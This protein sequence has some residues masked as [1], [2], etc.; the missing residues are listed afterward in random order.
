M[1]QAISYRDR[2]GFVIVKDQTVQRFVQHSYAGTYDHFIASGLYQHLVGEGLLITHT[3]INLNITE[4][5]KYYKVLETPFIP[6]ISYPYEW[7]A[8][9][10]KE[11][12]L[13]ILEINLI[14]I[15]YGMI[16]KDAT[17]FN[18]TFYHGKCIFID[19][20]SFETYTD[21]EPWIA[22]RQFCESMLGP[23]ALVFFN[24]VVWGR[25]MQSYINGWPLKMIS[26]NLPLHTW[27]KTA[28][29]FHIHLHAGFGKKSYIK[30]RGDGFSKEKLS[31]LWD[32]LKK[33]VTHWKLRSN[34]KIWSDYYDTGILSKQ[35][36]DHKLLMVSDWLKETQPHTVIDFGA[37][38]GLFS[39]TASGISQK[40]I[41]VESDHDCVEHLRQQIT[42]RKIQNIE[43]VLADIT[44]PTVATGWKN[45]E[46]QALLQRLKG[47]MV[48]SLALIHHLCISSNIPLPFIAELFSTL[49]TQYA[50][51]EF[52]PRTDP[53]VTDMLINRKDI[54]QDYTEEHFIQSFNEY[55]TLI[56]WANCDSS[57]RKLFLW[58]KK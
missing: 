49:T 38:N 19:T 47:D 6:F 48:L 57:E 2:D 56:K 24:E 31:M 26:S 18:C 52:I 10:W 35:Y 20:L 45:E 46:R 34:K 54:F 15:E 9:Q 22:Y 39:I 43:T 37:N 25:M 3:E 28:T 16:L 58:E 32:L 36:L 1:Q 5:S 13:N 4:S 17:P 53:K 29:L 51:V 7:T 21:G 40:V 33:S 30:K 50:L 23:A 42:D 44:Q 8:S 14:S 41:A 55:F 12:V 11:A 27:F